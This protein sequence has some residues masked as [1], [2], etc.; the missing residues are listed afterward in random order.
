MSDEAWQQLSVG[1]IDCSFVHSTHRSLMLSVSSWKFNDILAD[2][3][4]TVH[5]K[6]VGLSCERGVRWSC[7]QNQNCRHVDLDRIRV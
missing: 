4:S 3:I 2:I 5:E 7:V 1:F 6:G